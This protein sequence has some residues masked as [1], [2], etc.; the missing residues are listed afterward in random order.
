MNRLLYSTLFYLATPLLIL[1]LIWRSFKSPAYLHRW[2]ERFAF[3]GQ[4]SSAT[5]TLV[6]HAVSVG[7]VHAAVTLVEQ[8]L[9]KHPELGILVTTLTPTGSGRVV[10]LLGG[11]VTH[12]YLPYDYSGA[13]KRFLNHFN[14]VLLVIME[15]ELWPNLVN[16][17]QQQGVKVILA[18]ARLSEKSRHNYEKASHLT[19]T[20]LQQLEKV[21]AQ[22]TMDSERL[23]SLGLPPEK[24]LVTGSMKFDMV[25]NQDQVALAQQDKNGFSGRPV[26]VAAS[27]RTAEGVVEDE[28]VLTAFS[29]LLAIKPDLLLVLVPRHPE[30][31]NDVYDLINRQGF[32]VVRRSGNEKPA[33]QDQVL[34]GDSLGEMHYYLS[35]ADIAYVGGSLVPTGCQNIIEPAALGLPVV[36]GP[37]LYNF[38]SVSEELLV[39]K[40]MRVIQDAEELAKVLG[41]LFA[42]QEERQEMGQ[43]ALTVVQSN[44]G[45]TARNLELINN[46][47]DF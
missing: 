34:L 39:A 36:T 18:N 14:P 1:R 2:S 17:C 8:L 46:L 47:I 4:Q 42:D 35:L 30:R 38:Q 20:M 9:E 33:A 29:A 45:A 26:L 6:F 12:V 44:Q 43:A 5:T 23:Q 7:E 41:R 31:F 16:C 37:S 24:I 15:T 10:E 40:G 32:S 22:S 25:I 28:L 11:R 27:T 19:L 13:V 3:Y 21:T